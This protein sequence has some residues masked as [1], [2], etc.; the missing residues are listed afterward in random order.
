MSETPT[1]QTPDTVVEIQAVDSTTEIPAPPQD[2]TPKPRRYKKF[3]MAVV[4]AT[5][6][7]AVAAVAYFKSRKAQEPTPE[8][9]AEDLLV[10]PELTDQEILDALNEKLEEKKSSDSTPT[11]E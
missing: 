4:A 2:E 10:S 1:P 3:K 5:T 9:E 8:Q 11:S 7:A 6:M